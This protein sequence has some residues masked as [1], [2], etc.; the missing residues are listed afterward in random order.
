MTL[1]DALSSPTIS[2]PDAGRIFFGMCRSKAY[3]AARNGQIPTIE[4]NKSLLVPVAIVAKQ[5]GLKTKFES[6][7]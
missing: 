3:E 7:V 6:A 2:V 4:I 5:L 1:D